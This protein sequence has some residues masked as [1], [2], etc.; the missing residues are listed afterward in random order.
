VTTPD[1]GPS[2]TAH[3]GRRPRPGAPAG[4]EEVRRALLDAAEDLFARRRIDSVTLR[5]IAGHA[6]VQLS[7][8]SRYIG[9]RA[10]LVDAVF[11][12]LTHAMAVEVLE[13][14][15]DPIGFEHDPAMGRWTPMLAYRAIAGEDVSGVT[16]FNPVQAIADVVEHDYGL[17][18]DTARLRGAQVV[19]SALGWRLFEK[20]LVAA[21]GLEH[22]PVQVLRDQLAEMHHQV[23]AMPAPAAATDAPAETARTGRSATRARSR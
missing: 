2:R 18:P 16:E 23:A 15:D 9:T 14:P 10:Q 22:Q 3:H 8:I 12:D 6:H 5:E 20:Y 13:H 7:L 1:P 21:G 4:P 11:D 17:D 19:A